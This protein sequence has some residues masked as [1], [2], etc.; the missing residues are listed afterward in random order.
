MLAIPLQSKIF[1]LYM[2]QFCKI[3]MVAGV[4]FASALLTN[5]NSGQ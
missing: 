3:S 4:F 1:S 5:S 2:D